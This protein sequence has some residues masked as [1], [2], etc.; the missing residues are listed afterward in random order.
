MLEQ[1]AIH[2]TEK[3]IFDSILQNRLRGGWRVVPG[4]YQV[5]ATSQQ[6]AVGPFE[7]TTYFFVVIEI[8]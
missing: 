8:G 6:R 7:N 5:S 1:Q 2:T 4:T 3:D